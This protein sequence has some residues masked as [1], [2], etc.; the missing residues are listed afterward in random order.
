MSKKEQEA[1]EGFKLDEPLVDPIA[2]DTRAW[3]QLKQ[4]EG[5]T[6]EEF[7]TAAIEVLAFIV[8]EKL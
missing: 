4:Y 7:R 8:E 3:C 5:W 6:R 2:R 1:A